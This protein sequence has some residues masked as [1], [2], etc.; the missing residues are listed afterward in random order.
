[1]SREAKYRLAFNPPGAQA[2]GAQSGG[3]FRTL[4]G[5]LAAALVMNDS[6][7]TLLGVTCGGLPVMNGEDLSEAVGRLRSV[8]SECPGD[9]I[10]ACAGRVLRE[11][12][13][14]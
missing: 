11:M 1:M 3:D 8:A 14:E 2:S 9:N 4:A 6:G 10:I 7:M 12:N 13:L 5:A